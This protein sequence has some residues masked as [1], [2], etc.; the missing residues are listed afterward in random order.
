MTIVTTISVFVRS[1]RQSDRVSYMLKSVHSS[2]KSLLP[3]FCSLQQELYMTDFEKVTDFGNLYKAYKKAKSGKGYKKSSAKF[4]I[5][6]LEGIHLL[7]EQ[8]ENKQYKVSAYNQFY[9]YEPKQRLIEAAA[10][11]DK[12]VQHSLCDNVLLPKLQNVFIR[13]NF[14][15]QIGKGTLFGLNTLKDD[16]LN[17]YK[18]YGNNGYILKADITKFFYTIDHDV[19]KQIIRQHFDD[20]NLLWLCDLIIDSTDG[21][22]LPLGNQT[23]QV[24]ALLY[25]NGLDHYIKENL[26]IKYYGR[27]MDDFYL[28]HH[29]KEYLKYCLQQISKIVSDLKLSLNGK[30]QIMP[31]K[32]GIKFLGFHTYIKDNQVIC[33]IRNENKRNAYRKYKKMAYLVVEGKLSK[34]KFEECY[35]SW[36]AHAAFGDCENIISNLDKQIDEIISDSIIK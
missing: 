30:T 10:F 11:K 8:L 27:Y 20:E 24:F 9:V 1:G 33:R 35:Q 19:T 18:E 5:K 17:F 7:K 32:Q 25:L 16:M 22:G 4:E 12:V 26:N 15:G 13:N 3:F 14:A 2:Q 31:F 36:K 23:S 6:A 29:D 34:K 21:L 28:I